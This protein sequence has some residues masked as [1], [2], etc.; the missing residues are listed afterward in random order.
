[1]LRRPDRQAP[2]IPVFQIRS[3]ALRTH[4]LSMRGTWANQ[5]Q[6]D[7]RVPPTVTTQYA[8]AVH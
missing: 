8:C 4:P 2:Q 5:L 3:A 1:M 6:R 7:D